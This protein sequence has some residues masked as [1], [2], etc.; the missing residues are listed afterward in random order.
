MAQDYP[1][2]ENGKEVRSAA[3]K[4]VE[5]R[6][7]PEDLTRVKTGPGEADYEYCD[8]ASLF[9]LERLVPALK[10][11]TNKSQRYEAGKGHRKWVR[12]LADLAEP[13]WPEGGYL[14]Q[15]V[16]TTI[17]LGLSI[18]PEHWSQGQEI[19]DE[20]ARNAMENVVLPFPP[21]PGVD[22]NWV[23]VPLAPELEVVEPAWSD[24]LDG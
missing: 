18:S 12:D 22:E 19:V 20:F 6:P 10:G 23:P 4:V 5:P 24:G 1:V 14:R 2:D 16:M 3:K 11:C 8:P 21:Q 17:A 7:D 13:Y 9:A 15:R